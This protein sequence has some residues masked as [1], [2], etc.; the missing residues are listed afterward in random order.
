MKHKDKCR[1]CYPNLRKIGTYQLPP[2]YHFVCP[3]TK[4]QDCNLTSM[5]KTLSKLKLQDLEQ[6]EKN[7]PK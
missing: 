7:D 3:Q 2:T 5:A 1:N 6:T 4:G